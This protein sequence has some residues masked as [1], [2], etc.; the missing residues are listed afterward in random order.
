MV[1]KWLNRFVK[2][3]QNGIE[4]TPRVR[5][6]DLGDRTWH[7]SPSWAAAQT[8]LTTYYLSAKKRRQRA[9]LT[10]R[11]HA[12]PQ[13]SRPVPR[14]TRTSTSTTRRQVRPVPVDKEGPDGFLP[15]APLDQRL[16]EPD[17]LTYTLPVLT[18]PLH[19]TGPSEFRFWAITEGSDM[20]WVDTARG[21]R[22]QRQG[23]AHHSGLAAGELPVRRPRHVRARVRRTFRTT[24]R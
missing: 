22:T 9:V 1:L 12:L 19:L 13:A 16:D 5:W 20:D 23:A 17:G 8:S 11:R 24:T 4:N 10:E 18:K 14:A 15:Y 3:Q 2:G 6:F 21:R 7:S